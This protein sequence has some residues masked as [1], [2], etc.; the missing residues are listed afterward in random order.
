MYLFYT[1]LSPPAGAVILHKVCPITTANLVPL[2]CVDRVAAALFLLWSILARL[3][4][5]AAP[6]LLGLSSP[7][8]LFTS[9]LL[10]LFRSLRC[11]M[12]SSRDTFSGR[13]NVSTSKS[14]INGRAAKWLKCPLR[15]QSVALS[16]LLSPARSI[17]SDILLALVFDIMWAELS[18]AGNFKNGSPQTKPAYSS[19]LTQWSDDR[20]YGLKQVVISVSYSS[21]LC[22]RPHFKFP[23]PV[24]LSCNFSFWLS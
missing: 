1:H 24:I 22:R 9:E 19:S 10:C 2:L 14:S 21:A 11:R 6:L 12:L 15:T 4:R 8:W 20:F 17:S 5:L 23:W 13:R 18:T 16:H 7:I 3:T